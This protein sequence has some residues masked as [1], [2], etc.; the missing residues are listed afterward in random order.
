MV[1]ENQAELERKI[2]TY[3]GSERSDPQ[4]IANQSNATATALTSAGGATLVALNIIPVV[5]QV[6]SI[7]AGIVSIVQVF[8]NMKKA[9]DLQLQ[10]KNMQELELSYQQEIEVIVWETNQTLQLLKDEID[11]REQALRQQQT[12]LIIAGSVLGVSAMIFAYG[13]KKI[14]K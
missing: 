12:S 3:L 1:S 2:R 4:I 11:Y 10:I 6:V 5:G 8:D 13:L 14:N 7:V 9:Q